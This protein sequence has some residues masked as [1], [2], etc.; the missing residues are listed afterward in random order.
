MA[1]R[2]PPPRFRYEAIS[3]HYHRLPRRLWKFDVQL[4]SQ[5]RLPPLSTIISRLMVLSAWLPSCPGFLYRHPRAPNVRGPA[6]RDLETTHGAS[7]PR[8]HQAGLSAPGR[9]AQEDS[10]AE[11]LWRLGD[12][13]PNRMGDI[14]GLEHALGVFADMRRELG[15][16][17][18]GA[19]HRDTNPVLAQF[20]G[21]GIAESV[22]SPL[23]SRI[24]STVRQCV[25][26]R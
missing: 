24:G 21:G 20:F 18:A 9:W 5:L 17:G 3:L 14:L 6:K 7:R 1:S 2:V 4:F 13:H 26:S 16:R 23:R 15:I 11:R 22:E 12:E 19:N 8:A 25:L 10:A